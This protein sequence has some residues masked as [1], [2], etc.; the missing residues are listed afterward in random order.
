MSTTN[1]NSAPAAGAVTDV[2]DALVEYLDD[3][4]TRVDGR[5]DGSGGVAVTMDLANA[6]FTVGAS[7]ELAR[8]V[9]ELQYRI[10]TGP[11]LH[12]LRE[13]VGLY[14]PDLARDQRWGDYGPKA[15]EL[16]AA[17]CLSVPVIVAD[18]PA[19]V[20]KVYSPEIDGISPEQQALA[21]AAAPEVAGGL[22]LARLLTRQ[23]QDLDDRVAAMNSRRII[24]L[25]IG[26]I[27]DR[28]Q[29]GPDEAF[30]L[31]RRASQEGN[32]KLR[33]VAGELV[34]SVAGDE[35]V[36]RSAPFTGHQ[37]PGAPKDSQG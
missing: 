29:C 21:A 4:A 19:A 3:L 23:A 12:A 25:A 9:D 35:P 6:P 32:V 14:V 2:L 11:C 37:D 20:L 7:T 33:D 16:G 10:G 28:R 8:S 30:A 26:M 24:D 15:A 27:M 36:E 1:E 31:L 5:L 18:Q 34:G 13:G 22:G 17:S